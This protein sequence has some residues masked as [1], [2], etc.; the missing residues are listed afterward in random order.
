MQAE[1]GRHSADWEDAAT[2]LDRVEKELAEAQA[3]I[4]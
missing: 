1:L 2:E 4:G 3:T